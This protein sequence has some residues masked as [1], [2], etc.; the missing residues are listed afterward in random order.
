MPLLMMPAQSMAGSAVCQPIQVGDSSASM[1]KKAR[2]EPQKNCIIESSTASTSKTYRPMTRM[3]SEKTTAQASTKRSPAAIVKPSGGKRDSSPKERT[4]AAPKEET[5]DGD[6]DDIKRCD[7][8]RLA[9]FRIVHKAK[10]L[11]RFPAEETEP[12]EN[13]AH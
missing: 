12:A 10:L 13:P 9:Y 5:D 7:E 3:W 2:I 8:A 6:E 1:A 4:A 11:Q